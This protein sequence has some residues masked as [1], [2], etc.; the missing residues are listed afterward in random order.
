MVFSSDAGRRS[1]AINISALTSPEWWRVTSSKTNPVTTANRH[2]GKKI[3]RC[4][5][6][7]FLIAR[8]VTLS[9]FFDR[10]GCTLY[11]VHCTKSAGDG[12]GMMTE[13]Y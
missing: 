2:I 10:R 13:V 11:T 4:H 1:S 9:I 3:T 5:I 12:I 8:A 7:E 6:G